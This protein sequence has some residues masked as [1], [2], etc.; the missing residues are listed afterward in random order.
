MTVDRVGPSGR[1]QGRS[2]HLDALLSIDVD[3][4]GGYHAD[5]FTRHLVNMGKHSR[6]GCLTVGTSDRNTTWS[7]VREEHVNDCACDI[8]GFTFTRS[9]MHSETG[10]S[11]RL[12]DPAANILEGATNV[13][14]EEVNAADIEAVAAAR[15]AI[16]R[17]SG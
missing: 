8:T 5:L 7:T 12:A 10:R 17:L 13:G 2:C 9:N 6:R 15:I 11:I 14:G 16:S 3:A 1:K 4:V